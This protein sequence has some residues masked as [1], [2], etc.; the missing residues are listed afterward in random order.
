MNFG[1]IRVSTNTQNPGRQIEKMKAL[2]INDKNIYIDTKSGKNFNRDEYKALKRAIRPGDIIYID[3]LDRLGR[4]YVGVIDE[5]KEITREIN[6]DIVVLDDQNLFDSRKFKTMGELGQLLEDQMLAILAY[7]A[8]QR[9]EEIRRQQTEGILLAQKNGQKFGRPRL[10]NDNFMRAYEEWRAG[11][12]N[13]V[14]AIIKSKVSKSVFY[15]RVH[16]IENNLDTEI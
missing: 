4:N 10:P 5:W 13:A 7:I 1:Y 6:A 3:S 16:E 9:R 15:R 2:G 12:I 8:Q 11:K 14:Q